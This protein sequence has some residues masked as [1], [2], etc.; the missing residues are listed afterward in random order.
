LLQAGF[1]GFGGPT[2]AREPEDERDGESHEAREDQ[3]Q[4][5]RGQN[6]SS[7]FSEPLTVLLGVPQDSEAGA[8]PLHLA[9]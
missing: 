4:D 7:P 8:Q 5:Q 2:R 3:Q 1:D 6:Q 9:A